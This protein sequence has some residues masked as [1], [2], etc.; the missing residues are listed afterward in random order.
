[1]TTPATPVLAKSQ[2]RFDETKNYE[3]ILF[4]DGQVMQAAE[5]NEI[6]RT[7]EWRHNSVADKLF[8]DGDILSGADVRVIRIANNKIGIS[9]LSGEVYLAGVVRKVP[10]A[11]IGPIASAGTVI[12]G[13]RLRVEAITEVGDPTLNNPARGERGFSEPGAGRMKVTPFWALS[14]TPTTDAFYSLYTLDDGVLRPRDTPPQ[15]N[16]ITQAIAKY[17]IDSS[18][19]NYVIS[20]CGVSTKKTPAPTLADDQVYYIATG[21]LRVAGY[22]LN[23]NAMIS[24]TYTPEP[25]TQAVDLESHVAP[26]PSGGTQTVKT[27]HFPIMRVS[28]V[29]VLKTKTVTMTRGGSAGTSDQLGNSSI[30]S[31]TSVAQGGVTYSPGVDY[32]LSGES[33]SWVPAGIEPATGST[34][35]VTY[36]YRWTGPPISSTQTTVTT[37]GA[38]IGTSIFVDYEWAVPRVDVLCMNSDGLVEYV[39]GGHTHHVTPWPPAIPPTLIALA[40]IYQTWDARRAVVPTGIAMVSMETLSG[41]QTKLDRLLMLTAQDRLKFDANFRDASIKKSIISD[42]FLDDTLRDKRYLAVPQIPEAATV[43]GALVL[44]VALAEKTFPNAGATL[45]GADRTLIEQLRTTGRIKVNPYMTGTHPPATA[46]LTPSCD[47]WVDYEESDVST[48][49]RNLYG[50]ITVGAE[51]ITTTQDVVTDISLTQEST[52]RKNNVLFKITGFAPEETIAMAKIGNV[53]IPAIEGQ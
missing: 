29:H 27:V 7:A 5:F 44:P 51:S 12:V 38:I 41:V 10:K 18:G 2:D 31:I 17:D 37:A 20:G 52:M 14:T 40:K 13:I 39:K 16:A 22:A 1:M 53:V 46:T 36:V 4:R 8:K 25:D 23:I 19:S 21:R 35:Q 26:A 24:S 33:V 48:R 45:D 6:Q 28:N 32:Q 49:T 11:D 3:R 47:Y 34:Y 42:P 9:C 50:K 15:A 30:E 43:N